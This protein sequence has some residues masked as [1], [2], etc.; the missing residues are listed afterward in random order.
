MRRHTEIA[1]AVLQTFILK[2]EPRLGPDLDNR[3]ENLALLIDAVL[4]LSH[5]PKSRAALS[6]TAKSLVTKY[7][8]N[9][10]EK[11]A[12]HLRKI[13]QIPLNDFTALY[14]AS[15]H[16]RLN[17]VQALL[18][19]GYDVNDNQPDGFTALM[20]ACEQGHFEVVKALIAAGAD[21]NRANRNG[22]R[23]LTYALAGKHTDIA[24]FLR[25]HG[26]K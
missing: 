4:E 15:Y 16:G 24:D 19:E 2:T 14:D 12:Y 20:P 18:G 10:D 23:A 11:K 25:R 6:A 5:D 17:E 9:V 7:D 13:G 26:A 21:V 1:P 3:V 22:D 8:C